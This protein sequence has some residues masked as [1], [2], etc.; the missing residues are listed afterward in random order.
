MTTA[1]SQDILAD[2]IDGCSEVIR[3]SLQRM[4]GLQWHPTGDTDLD[5]ARTAAL[6]KRV[7][8]LRK[9]REQLEALQAF[10]P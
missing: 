9:I 4:D 8:E 5:D 3:I 7:V 10:A 1:T 6:G 2:C